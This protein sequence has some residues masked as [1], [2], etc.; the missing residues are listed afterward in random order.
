MLLKNGSKGSDVKL[1]QE[2]LGLT[3]DGDFGPATLNAVTQLQ[4]K[5]NIQPKGGKYG[6]FGPITMGK[7]ADYATSNPTQPAPQQ[8]TPTAQP[9][10]QTQTP[11]PDTT[12]Q[13][14]TTQEG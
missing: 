6:M 14:D 9:E 5:L 2:K 1:L 10:Q 11:Q 3:A 4:K 7:M 12:Q 8:S 13:T